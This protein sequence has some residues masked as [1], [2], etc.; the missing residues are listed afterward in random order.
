MVEHAI[1]PE[2]WRRLSPD[3]RLAYAKRRKAERR[4]FLYLPRQPCRLDADLHLA[5]LVPPQKTVA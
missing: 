3:S 4:C 1:P 2:D 5:S